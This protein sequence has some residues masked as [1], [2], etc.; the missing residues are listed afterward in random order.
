MLS[1]PAL[2][3]CH[4]MLCCPA[5]L[6]SLVLLS[7]HTVVLLSCHSVLSRFLCPA[8]MVS[9]RLGSVHEAWDQMESVISC[10]LVLLSCPAMPKLSV[11]LYPNLFDI[12]ITFTRGAGMMQTPR[13]GVS[14]Y[15]RAIVGSLDVGTDLA[16]FVN[17]WREGGRR[18]GG[19]RGGKREG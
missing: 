3:C 13:L 14:V 18:A 12:C 19:R 4:I 11:L 6:S 2:S 9:S 10:H 16:A 5:V 17:T 7:Y 1:C 15:A 8:L